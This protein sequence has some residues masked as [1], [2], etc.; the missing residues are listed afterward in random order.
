M[1]P[2]PLRFRFGL[3]KLIKGLRRIS[4]S[5]LDSDAPD[6]LSAL[7]RLIDQ[8]PKVNKSN[9]VKERASLYY[10]A[11][12][13]ESMTEVQDK[14]YDPAEPTYYPAGID[15]PPFPQEYVTLSTVHKIKGGE[16]EKVLYLGTDDY[17]YEKYRSFKGKNKRAEIL[18]MNVA[19]SRAGSE[20]TLLFPI[21]MKEWKSGKNASNP[22]TIIRNAAKELYRLRLL[23]FA[24][25]HGSG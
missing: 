12:T 4:S 7:E 6:R 10:F 23:N 13:S 15:K 11:H 22:W 24:D 2:R 14:Y 8:L 5:T 25:L 19:C 16:F 21:G 18:L 17:L 20:L 3:Q 9:N 1:Y